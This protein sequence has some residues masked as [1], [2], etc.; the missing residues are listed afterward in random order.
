M[1]QQKMMIKATC[2]SCGKIKTK[3]DKSKEGDIRLCYLFYQNRD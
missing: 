3:F 1:L 2:A